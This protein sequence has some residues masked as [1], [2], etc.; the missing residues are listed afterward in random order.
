V[1]YTFLRCSESGIREIAAMASSQERKR[2]NVPHVSRRGP[3]S[4]GRPAKA[5]RPGMNPT[6]ERIYAAVKRIPRGRVATYA[7]IAVV[8]GLSGQPRLVGYALNALPDSLPVPWQRVINARGEISPR[9]DPRFEQIQ[10]AMLERE[11]IEFGTG[12]RVALARYRWRPR[13]GGSAKRGRQRI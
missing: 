5:P 12:G 2:A 3:N 13:G 10:R 6:Y 7:Q 8:A 9:S 4:G 11:G 1:T